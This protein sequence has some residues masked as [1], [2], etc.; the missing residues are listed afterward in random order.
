MYRCSGHFYTAGQHTLMDFQ[1]VITGSAERWDQGWMDIDH[2]VSVFCDH[3]C[4]NH[5]K[6]SGQYDQIRLQ[7]I[8]SLH[9]FLIENLTAFIIFWRNALIRNAVFLGTLQCI[10]IFIITDHTGDLRVRDHAGIYR[11]YDCL[12]IRS[13]AGYQNYDI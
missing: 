1:S 8:Y 13:A 9:K 7:S 5:Y 12:Q 11:I 3:F 4:R 2:T 10:C 6:E